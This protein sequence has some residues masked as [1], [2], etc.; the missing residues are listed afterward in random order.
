MPIGWLLK[1][2][3]LN[4]DF[5]SFANLQPHGISRYYPS[6]ARSDDFDYLSRLARFT[7]IAIC[8]NQDF[9]INGFKDFSTRRDVALQRLNT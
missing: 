2:H 7:F 1:N 6:R 3:F 4:N 5:F 8:Q 9:K